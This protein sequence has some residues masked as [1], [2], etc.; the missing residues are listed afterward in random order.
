MSGI[1][2]DPDCADWGRGP[3]G[4]IGDGCT[5]IAEGVVVA[6]LTVWWTW[7]TVKGWNAC[8][9]VPAAAGAALAAS[10]LFHVMFGEGD[11]TTA[12]AVVTGS[13]DSDSVAHGI[14]LALVNTREVTVVATVWGVSVAVWLFGAPPPWIRIAIAMYSALT[15]AAAAAAHIEF[16]TKVKWYIAY[17]AVG[18]LLGAA[19][20]ADALGA[21][22][23]PGTSRPV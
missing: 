3:V 18:A 6:V 7:A 20:L 2:G 11:M 9:T 5:D 12:A 16:A 10:S 23:G 19:I 8:A 1:F 4:Q 14:V 13:G 17:D 15:A 22:D 21:G